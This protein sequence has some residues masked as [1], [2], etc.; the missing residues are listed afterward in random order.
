MLVG[1]AD[2]HRV[3]LSSMIML[4]DN[5]VWSTGACRCSPALLAAAL[6][7]AF[8]PTTMRVPRRL[9]HRR[10][11]QGQVGGR[12]CAQDRGRGPQRSRGRGSD[13]GKLEARGGRDGAL[14]RALTRQPR[15]ARRLS[16]VQAGA[17]IVM[18]DNF[19]PAAMAETAAKLKARHPHVLLEG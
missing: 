11:G 1:G 4:K 9:D 15:R 5:H 6:P 13:C 12:L 3:D 8:A 18:L 17:D 14:F 2:T 7:K 10:R 16:G 19:K